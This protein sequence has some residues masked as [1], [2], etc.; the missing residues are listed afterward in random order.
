MCISHLVSRQKKVLLY[1]TFFYLS[2]E[3]NHCCKAKMG[4]ILQPVSITECP[5]L[6]PTA[7]E[8]EHP[9]HYLSSEAVLAQGAYYGI[10]KI[11]PPEGWKPELA[12]NKQEFSFETRLQQLPQLS[13]RNRARVDFLQG[14][15]NFQRF[16]QRPTIDEGD[17][18]FD[19]LYIGVS[20]PTI[21][22]ENKNK[23]GWIHLVNGSRVHIHDIL[24][25]QHQQQGQLNWDFWINLASDK[26]IIKDVIIYCQYITQ[27]LNL[28]SSDFFS[29]GISQNRDNNASIL[30]MYT[31]LDPEIDAHL[32][33]HFKEPNDTLLTPISPLKYF[34]QT[35]ES[36][37]YHIT[38]NEEER[39]LESIRR[40]ETINIEITNPTESI[41][42]ISSLQNKPLGQI[43]IP[44]QIDY[45]I[46]SG[47]ANE[48]CK[49]CHLAEGRML[50]CE[51]CDDSY[52]KKCLPK[53]QSIYLDYNSEG[54][55]MCPLC[56]VGGSGEYGFEHDGKM[57][58]LDSF[59]NYCANEWGDNSVFKKW[60]HSLKKAIGLPM[61][62]NSLTGLSENEFEGLFWSLV[63]G[64]ISLPKDV[65]IRYGA[66]INNTR[67]DQI[68]GFPTKETVDGFYT[69]DK[70]WVK[71]TMDENQRKYINDEWNLT[72]LPFAKGSF[73]KYICDTQ[74]K[75]VPKKDV[76]NGDPALIDLSFA[77]ASKMTL[78][79]HISG[80]SVPWVYVGGPF[81]TFC[82]HKEDHY[83]MSANYCHTGSPKQ[84]YGIP[85]S[86]CEEFERRV[87]ELVSPDMGRKQGDIMH[88]LVSQIP[89]EDIIYCS[90][91]NDLR[92]YK[93]K[94]KPGQFIITFPR[95]YHSGFNYGFNIN[96][97]VN[98]TNI[99]WMRY[100]PMAI[101]EYKKVKKEPVF[102]ILDLVRNIKND[103]MENERVFIDD[104][105]TTKTKMKELIMLGDRIVQK[106]QTFL[107]Q[108]KWS[109]A[110]LTKAIA[111]MKH[112]SIEQYLE[113]LG[114]DQYA[115]E[116]F[117]KILQGQEQEQEE[118]EQ[119]QEEVGL[120]DLGLCQS[121]K[122]R[123]HLEW[124]EIDFW[125]FWMDQLQG[126][127][128]ITGHPSTVMSLSP[129]R[130][131]PF[132]AGSG[133]Y[134]S[135]LLSRRAEHLAGM[136]LRDAGTGRCVLCLACFSRQ[137]GL[138]VSTADTFLS[139]PWFRF[140]RFIC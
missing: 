130:R 53:T 20:R 30:D 94:Q 57:F 101:R 39:D 85:S 98:F 91:G 114:R 92:I 62:N 26:N 100:S 24:V 5:T 88:Q 4:S 83:T 95:A 124:V 41:K 29:F 90:G 72:N 89:L 9:I 121:C 56:L 64:R 96:E 65:T 34:S 3:S 59:E 132:S 122:T 111:R 107:Q 1:A 55:W 51:S 8:F 11:Q 134:S 131:Q 40:K 77:P 47:D 79:D 70:I 6:Y 69:A 117:R 127:N 125:L 50:I 33:K 52:H 80:M 116:K 108:L 68:T 140:G 46:L 119:E 23:F 48:R 25:S 21:D 16:H 7:E 18:D 28:E 54:D 31:S 19:D 15:N 74:R 10:L 104:N 86:C 76:A 135:E 110:K 126:Q 82:W 103:C 49:I 84:W 14:F 133:F 12:L 113:E 45:N 17:D 97:A 99:D 61:Y 38:P 63:G 112:V 75:K 129:K 13:L 123:V 137:I 118:H 115:S 71:P 120:I 37:L 27:A 93:A 58:T 136:R 60:I 35:I 78:P 81:S 2:F 138:S 102:D 87:K 43:S 42:A 66:D 73:F 67:K 139:S 128:R 22:L 106:E 36:F 105:G 32:V 109:N 44:N